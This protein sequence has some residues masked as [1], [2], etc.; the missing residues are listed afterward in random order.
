MTREQVGEYFDAVRAKAER[1]TAGRNVEA[2]VRRLV[3]NSLCK[4]LELERVGTYL[5]ICCK[6]LVYYLTN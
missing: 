5:S 4:E 1:E 2:T 6:A 3:R